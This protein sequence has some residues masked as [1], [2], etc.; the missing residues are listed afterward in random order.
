MSRTVVAKGK[1]MSAFFA[2]GLLLVMLIHAITELLKIIY[3][4]R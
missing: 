4:K 3:R 1:N 2:G